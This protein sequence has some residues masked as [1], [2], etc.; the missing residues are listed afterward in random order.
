MPVLDVRNP[1]FA[2]EL[3]ARYTT[4]RVALIAWTQGIEVP[5]MLTV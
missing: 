5:A 3:L 2:A 4:P 1:Q